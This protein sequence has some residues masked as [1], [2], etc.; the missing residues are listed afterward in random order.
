MVRTR[1]T[2]IS[3]VAL[4]AMSLLSP[5]RAAASQVLAQGNY[6]E[7]ANSDAAPFSKNDAIGNIKK[8]NVTQ[9][10]GG[11]LK[12]TIDYWKLP[13]NN[14]TVRIRWCAPDQFD[15][16]GD[17]ELGI[18][19]NSD[20]DYLNNLVFFSPAKT[21]KS[22]QLGLRKSFSGSSK[23]GANANQWIYT[24]K[25]NSLISKPMGLVEV[26]MYY[27]SSI[28]TE[29]T[30]TCRGGYSITCNTRSSNVFEGDDAQVKLTSN[31][32]ST[33]Q[34]YS[35]QFLTIQSY[36][37]KVSGSYNPSSRTFSLACNADARTDGIVDG[38]KLLIG[39]STN[40]N[41]VSAGQEW[42]PRQLTPL[43]AGVA[44]TWL[45]NGSPYIMYIEL[46]FTSPDGNRNP[47]G[48]QAAGIPRLSEIGLDVSSA[49]FLIAGPTG[50]ASASPSYPRSV[51]G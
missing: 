13:S 32:T 5:I 22:Y 28:F 40:P 30:T 3:I 31:A 18:C 50:F 27:S 14:H 42:F 8:L 39:I 34:G 10:S 33:A 44:K 38:L 47:C 45:N 25:G 16:Y 36:F 19:N 12:V 29:V 24:I 23:K 15:V 21:T 17:E 48:L 9:S 11:I 41:G 43:Y 51:I 6:S 20:K 26:Q 49:I 2:I 37:D 46:P 4:I 1:Y 7:N 35:R